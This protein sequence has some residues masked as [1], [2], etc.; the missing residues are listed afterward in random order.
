MTSVEAIGAGFIVN[1]LFY[2]TA[3]LVKKI[4]VLEVQL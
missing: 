2:S 4:T 1:L 3:M